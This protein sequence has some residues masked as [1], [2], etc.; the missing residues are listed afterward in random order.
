MVKAVDSSGTEISRP[1]N[2]TTEQSSKFTTPT[3]TAELW[4]YLSNNDLGS[5]T[6]TFE[7]TSLL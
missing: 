7:E 6:Y 4:I 2:Y 3:G 5:G 1:I